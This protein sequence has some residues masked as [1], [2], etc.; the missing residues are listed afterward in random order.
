[1]RFKMAKLSKQSKEFMVKLLACEYPAHIK[2]A[3]DIF[4]GKT[5]EELVKAN[6]GK[7]HIKANELL[8]LAEKLNVE[9]DDDLMVTI[10]WT[11][12]L[13]TGVHG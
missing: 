11:L 7:K 8:S 12:D 10:E 3:L 2:Y 5:L 6:G 1:M 9:I 13:P 4:E